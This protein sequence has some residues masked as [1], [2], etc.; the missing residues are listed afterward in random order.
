MVSISFVDTVLVF[1]HQLDNPFK[2]DFVNNNTNYQ[3]VNESIYTSGI[4]YDNDIKDFFLS[5]ADLSTSSITVL[6]STGAPEQIIPFSTSTEEIIS[7][8]TLISTSV[9]EQPISSIKFTSP[10][11]TPMTIQ[12]TLSTSS[13]PKPTPNINV[14]ATLLESSKSDSFFSTSTSSSATSL[15]SSSATSLASSFATSSA[16]ILNNFAATNNGQIFFSKSISNTSTGSL[17]TNS[18][19]TGSLSTSS[20]PQTSNTQKTITYTSPGYVAQ[21]QLISLTTSISPTTSISSTILA[22]SSSPTNSKPKFMPS[23]VFVNPEEN[24]H[25]RTIIK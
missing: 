22:S 7:F 15:A 19:F 9:S 10:V 11:L 2:Y 24:P 17:S 16:S 23:P 12:K 5:K 20:S 25:G 8:S 21:S 18:L 14:F 4:K 6:A 13:Q 3:A 1:F